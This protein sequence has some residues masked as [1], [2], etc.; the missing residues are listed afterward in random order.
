MEDGPAR[1]RR[2]IEPVHDKALA[3][4]VATRGA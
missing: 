1:F 4:H 3:F 2:L